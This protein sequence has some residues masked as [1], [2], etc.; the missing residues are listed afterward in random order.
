MEAF[1]ACFSPHTG[2]SGFAAKDLAVIALWGLGGL[3]SPRAVSNGKPIRAKTSLAARA[4]F[5][6][7]SREV[8][9]EAGRPAPSFVRQPLTVKS[10]F[11]LPT[12]TW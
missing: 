6:A 4:G 5:A 11:M 12:C 1:T 8:E 3:A 7:F 2:G 10:A 9:E